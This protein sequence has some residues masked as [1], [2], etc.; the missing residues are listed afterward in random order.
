MIKI[1]RNSVEHIMTVI[2]IY[3]QLTRE[4]LD[5]KL[6]LLSMGQNYKD[7]KFKKSVKTSV[8]EKGNVC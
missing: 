5:Y 4:K 2:Y 1:Y 8:K 3:N 6:I 7:T